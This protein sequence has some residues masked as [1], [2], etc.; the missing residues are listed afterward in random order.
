ME[1]F[2]D[3]KDDF[4]VAAST[5]FSSITGCVVCFSGV[6]F[7]SFVCSVTTGAGLSGVALTLTLDTTVAVAVVVGVVVVAV[8]ADGV[9]V[10]TVVV[11]GVEGKEGE[12]RRRGVVSSVG[13]NSEGALGRVEEGA[14][15]AE[16]EA[17]TFELSCVGRGTES[18]AG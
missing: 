6:A 17:V 14:E 2:T 9:T 4:A 5:F 7:S 16:E 11:L 8:E 3:E 1:S 13:D 10:V 12:G 18:D 15:A